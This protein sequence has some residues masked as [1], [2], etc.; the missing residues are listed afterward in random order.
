MELFDCSPSPLV[1][2]L[3]VVSAYVA[4]WWIFVRSGTSTIESWL[5]GSAIGTCIGGLLNIALSPLFCS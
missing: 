2:V 1:D 5:I 4:S 3:F